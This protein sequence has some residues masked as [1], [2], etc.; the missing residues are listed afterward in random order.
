MNRDRTLFQVWHAR[1]VLE[2]VETPLQH[3][4][5]SKPLNP[6]Q[7][8]NHVVT[9][10]EGRIQPV[11][12]S[13]DH[14]LRSRRFQ[15]LVRHHDHD[16]SVVQSSTSST[17]RH[18]DVFSRRQIPKVSTVEFPHRREDDSF[19]GH[20]E[21][22]GKC[23]GGEKD[24]DETFLEENFD[25]FFQDREE[26]SVMNSDPTFE[27]GEDVLNLRKGTIVVGEIRDGVGEDARHHIALLVGVEFE[28]GHLEGKPFT[29]TFREGEYD[30]GIVV[31]DHNHLDDLVDIRGSFSKNT[32]QPDDLV[33]A[34]K[35]KELTFDTA[36]LGLS[37]ST[38][39]SGR[40]CRIFSFPFR[41]SS[42]RLLE[43]ILPEGT[44]LVDDQVNS[45]SSSGKE[46]VL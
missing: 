14:V 19:G 12:F 13:F 35:I 41:K 34:S 1:G 28:F 37:F 21:T 22:D 10:M 5:G 45:V 33:G 4:L 6:H 20:V 29:F 36:L 32:T 30:D 16:S 18:L 24:F 25:D 27:E 46:V 17:T 11:G 38:L 8:Q 31:L 7:V 44:F 42:H 9:E 43:I 2:L 40:A 3:V 39:S 26:S 23:F 15:L